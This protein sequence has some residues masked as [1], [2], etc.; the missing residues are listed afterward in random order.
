MKH[1]EFEKL[2][3]DK[4]FEVHFT[5][6]D[7]FVEHN[8]KTVAIV[9]KEDIGLIDLNW[10]QYANLPVETRKFIADKCVELAF[11]E[12]EDREE[13]EK[14][15]YKLKGFMEKYLNVFE[16]A[17]GVQYILDGAKEA[18]LLGNS[19]KTQFTDAEFEALP[20]DIQSHNW[21]KIKVESDNQ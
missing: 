9:S 11:T 13:E 18:E 17:E 14:Y 10:T 6:S 5:I 19:F 12:L 4:G 15:Y 7:V 1:S 2:M 20:K 21:E 8:Y 16:H 3:E